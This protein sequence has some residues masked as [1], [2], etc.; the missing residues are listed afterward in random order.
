MEL[1]HT[2]T[3]E[4]AKAIERVFTSLTRVIRQME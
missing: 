1:A 3:Q 2:T 4:L